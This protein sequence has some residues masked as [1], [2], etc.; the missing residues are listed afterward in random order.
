MSHTNTL[1]TLNP[2]GESI[3]ASPE[4][5]I[6][7]AREHLSRRLRRGTSLSS[8]QAVCDFL[9]GRLGAREFECPIATHFGASDDT[10]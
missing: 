4:D 1:F 8:P 5:I 10:A 6:A 7:A 3:P 2:A 9:A